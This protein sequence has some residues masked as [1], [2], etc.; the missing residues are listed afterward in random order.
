MLIFTE[1]VFLSKPQLINNLY[2]GFAEGQHKENITA[3][4]SAS[5]LSLHLWHDQG[6]LEL[7]HKFFLGTLKI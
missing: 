1:A 7:S 5:L 2:L 4:S 6:V 3:F